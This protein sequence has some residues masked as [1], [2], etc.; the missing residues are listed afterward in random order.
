MEHAA[1]LTNSLML[2][3]PKIL[4]VCVQIEGAE[5]RNP[6]RRVRANF[7]DQ[8][9]RYS[10]FVTDPIAEQAFLAKPDGRYPLSDTYLCVSLA[11]AHDDGDR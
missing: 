3:K 2:I 7:T 5:F 4:N 6:K 1:E 10:L 9:I 11:G 8:D